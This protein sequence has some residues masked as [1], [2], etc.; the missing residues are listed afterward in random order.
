MSVTLT[1]AE[2]TDKLEEAFRMGYQTG[3]VV[4]ERQTQ[5]RHMRV[6]PVDAETAAAFSPRRGFAFPASPVPTNTTPAA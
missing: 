3:K 5:K 4:G 6:I 2:L 1:Q